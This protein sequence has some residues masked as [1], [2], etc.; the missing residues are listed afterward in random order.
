M[1]DRNKSVFRAGFGEHFVFDLLFNYLI[2]DFFHAGNG[3]FL[4]LG[5]QIFNIAVGLLK[6]SLAHIVVDGGD[7]QVYPLL[8]EQWG[9]MFDGY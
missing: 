5:F 2:K 1:A 8:G 7:I 4:Y 6:F 3:G 9:I